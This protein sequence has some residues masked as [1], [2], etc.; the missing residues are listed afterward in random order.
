MTPG[1]LTCE[2]PVLRSPLKQWD[3]P[4]WAENEAEPD[5]PYTQDL[6][7]P[8]GQLII[9][10]SDSHGNRAHVACD[11]RHP[12]DGSLMT[13]AANPDS[14]LQLSVNVSLMTVLDCD[15]DRETLQNLWQLVAYYYESPAI[16]E[17][18]QQR[19]NTS[20]VTYQYV[21]VVSEN[22]PYFTELKGY[23]EA[24]PSWLLQPRITLKLNRQQTNTKKLVMDFTTLIRKEINGLRGQDEDNY[25]SSWALIR[26]GTTGRVQAAFEGSK[27]HLECNVITSA[28]EVKVEWMLP[29]LSTVET[30]TKKIEISERG[31]LIILNATLS[32]SGLYYCIVR[33][34]A[35]V[36]LMP[37]RLTVKEHLLGPTALNGEKITVQKGNTLSLPCDVMSVQPS[38]TW[39]YLP[40][41]QVL[42][43]T[44]QTR[45]AE[46]MPNGTLVV[47]RM[48]QEDAGGYS[49]LASN[50]YGTDMLSHTVE[51]VGEETSRKSKVQTEKEQTVLT[52]G[53]EDREGSGGDYQE[54]IRPFATQLP[55]KVVRPQRKPNGFLNRVKASKR[56]PNKSV[57]EL[58]PNRWAEILAKANLKPGSLLPTE[59][60]LEEPSTVTIH[61]TTSKPV[62]VGATVSTNHL[63]YFTTPSYSDQTSSLHQNVKKGDHYKV[64]EILKNPQQVLLSPLPDPSLQHGIPDPLGSQANSHVSELEN[65]HIGEKRSNSFVVPGVSN[66]RQPFHRRRKP[67]LRRINQDKNPLHHSFRKTQM[68]VLTPTTTTTTTTTI[69]TTTTSATS[70]T[71]PTPTTT[72]NPESLSFEYQTEGDYDKY[73][74]EYDYDSKHLDTTDDM[75]SEILQNTF[76]DN[77][78]TPFP[79]VTERNPSIVGQDL[80]IPPPKRKSTTL[81][82]TEDLVNSEKSMVESEH[83]REHTVQN[84]NNKKLLVENKRTSLA[85]MEQQEKVTKSKEKLKKELVTQSYS[86]QSNIQLHN[87]PMPNVQPAPKQISSTHTRTLSPKDSSSGR[88]MEEFIQMEDKGVK[89]SNKKPES[90]HVLV[91]EPLHPWLQ[92]TNQGGQTTNSRVTHTNQDRNTKNL[93]GMNPSRHL[94]PPRVPPT[95]HWS[96]PHYPPH[97]YP[98]YPSWPGQRTFPQPR[99]GKCNNCVNKYL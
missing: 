26:R 75:I 18:G 33:T 80:S 42:L 23:L 84:K 70:T 85:T 39:W 72:E 35:G 77:S 21:Q 2:R 34:K 48:T 69:T 52:L 37:L 59:P 73:Y 8:L 3:N 61:R 16:L 6:E 15:I 65:K 79:L 19:V 22:S 63:H 99:Q 86:T 95:S 24:E 11:V 83:D 78:I 36:D 68:S 93:G 91:M 45:K 76:L 10:L 31:Q 13:W 56:K 27:V 1:K 29:D 46:V 43:P 60:S 41:K 66:R 64:P 97:Y 40:K 81:W 87:R 50:L 57:K 88:T 14:P 71:I 53:M 90:H 89:E 82:S 25:A 30:P 12:R 51:V 28:P 7:K 67:L 5:L 32:D 98:I 38:Q 49:C 58:D 20:R 47:K 9:V 55:E 4:V 54:T 74:E 92:H 62:T 44:Q 94:Q 96:N 17:R